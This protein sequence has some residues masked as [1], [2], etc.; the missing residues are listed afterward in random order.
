MLNASSEIFCILK[1][2][3]ARSS[4]NKAMMTPPNTATIMEVCTA[5]CTVLSSLLPTAFAITTLVPSEMPRNP[6][7]MKL[8]IGVFAPTAAM[9]AS[10]SSPV[11]FPTTAMSAAL[12]ACC[13]IPVMAK[14]KANPRILFQRLPSVMDCFLIFLAFI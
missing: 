2:G 9:Q 14:G 4:P 12:N 13:R 11:K 7:M 5:F 8:I 6:L 10:P 1:I 3:S